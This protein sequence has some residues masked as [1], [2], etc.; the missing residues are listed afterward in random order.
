MLGTT[1]MSERRVMRPPA[2]PAARPTLR[3]LDDG[4]SEARL[5]E[6]KEIARSVDP[7]PSAALTL[8][9]AKL[10]TESLAFRRPKFNPAEKDLSPR[11]AQAHDA[12][13]GVSD[14]KDRSL[15]RFAHGLL[16]AVDEWQK[17]TMQRKG[18]RMN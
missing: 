6:A 13:R 10:L 2:R 15:L 3:L 9:T 7:K 17:T 12:V 16:A 5:F 4:P 14:S 11:A 1:V 18:R 8:W